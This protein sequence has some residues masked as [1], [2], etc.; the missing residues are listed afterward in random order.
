MMSYN[1]LHNQLNIKTKKMKTTFFYAVFIAMLCC[2][3]NSY[4]Q[5]QGMKPT[6]IGKAEYV[7][8]VPAI[9]KMDNVISAKGMIKHGQEKKKGKNT[10]VPGKGLPAAGQNDPLI[11]HSKEAKS[12]AEKTSAA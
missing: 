9:S 3:V 10:F 4:A 5:K 11:I 2:T 7:R 6:T 12:K 1:Y 8:V